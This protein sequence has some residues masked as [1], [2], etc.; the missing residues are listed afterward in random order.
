M[1]PSEYCNFLT[2]ALSFISQLFTILNDHIKINC[3]FT[4]FKHRENQLTQSCVSRTRDT[5]TNQTL[6][7][8]KCHKH[9]KRMLICFADSRL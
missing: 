8:F 1:T 2:R 7:S 4:K 3:R 6:R 5:V 9:Y